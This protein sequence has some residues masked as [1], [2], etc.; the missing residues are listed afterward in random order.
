M[1][2]GVTCPL[3]L[4][5]KIVSRSPM[6][7]AARSRCYN[8][9]FSAIIL[10]PK[11]RMS[12]SNPRPGRAR[13]LGQLGPQEVFGAIRIGRLAETVNAAARGGRIACAKAPVYEGVRYNLVLNCICSAT[14]KRFCRTT[15]R[16]HM[17]NFKECVHICS[18]GR[19]EEIANTIR[20]IA[21]EWSSYC[22]QPS[23]QIVPHAYYDE[24]N[25][26]T[27]SATR[28]LLSVSCA[29]R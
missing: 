10:Q 3:S 8:A 21:C 4:A 7:S 25:P 24:A 23:I 20:F 27:A 17:C 6:K 14:R 15:R 1:R 26:P 5:T 22:N 2:L 9:P 28:H 11:H 19:P 13:Q 12:Y 16:G 29:C 18:F